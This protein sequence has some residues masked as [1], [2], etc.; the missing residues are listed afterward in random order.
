M[1]PWGMLGR[2]KWQVTILGSEAHQS[3]GFGH[4]KWADP[5]CQLGGPGTGAIAMAGQPLCLEPV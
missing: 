3:D 4:P 2:H 5:L 1:L